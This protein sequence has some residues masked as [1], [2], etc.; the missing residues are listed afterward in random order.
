MRVAAARDGRQRSSWLV[1]LLA[2]AVWLWPVSVTA[3]PPRPAR[4][5]G[6]VYDS[7]QRAPLVG[8]M[9]DAVDARDPLKLWSATTDERGEFTLDALPPGSYAVAVSHPRLDALGIRQLSRGVVLRAGDRE[10]VRLGVPSAPSLI[11]RVCGDSM[12]AERSGFLRGVL[13][14]V[15]RGPLAVPG[16]IRLEWLELSITAAGIGRQIASLEARADEEGRFTACGV[17]AEGVLQVRA[18]HGADS[19]GVLELSVPF[20]GLLLRDLYVGRRRTVALTLTDSTSGVTPV[21]A[22]GSLADS[23]AL[24]VQVTRGD[25]VL[26]GL[27]RT[28]DGA[29]VPDVRVAM[30]GTGLDVR[31][32]PDGQFVL[33]DVPTGSHTLDVRAIGYVPLRRVVDVGADDGARLEVALER[34]ARL[35]T[36]RIMATREER[37]ATRLADFENNRRLRVTGR[38]ITPEALAKQPPLR[39]ADVFRLIPGVRVVPAA[40]GDQVV[41]RGQSFSQWC[42]PELWIDGVRAVNTVGLDMLVN[43]QDVLAVEVYNSGA[44]V[45]AQLA[46][47]SGCGAIVFHTGMRERPNR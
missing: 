11:R 34:M 14:D 29:A 33:S 16:T 24:Q 44:G 43:A 7:T 13:R 35:D 10:R 25:G 1:L 22:G 45:P 32:G 26:R 31:S 2:L 28:A 12:A 23:S 3:Q 9:I 46:G 6:A 47:F 19:T 42:T 27:I 37:L 41:M 36:V 17:P 30:W 4:L 40:G 18:W 38:F 20:D 5:T 21:A 39:T 8:A 15:A